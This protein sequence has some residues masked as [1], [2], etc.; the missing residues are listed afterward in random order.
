[1]QTRQNMVELISRHGGT[2]IF[3]AKDLKLDSLRIP[4]DGRAPDA[5]DLP[6]S[7]PAGGD[8]QSPDEHH[9]DGAGNTQ[10]GDEGLPPHTEPKGEGVNTVHPP[11]LPLLRHDCTLHAKRSNLC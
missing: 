9:H 8:G 7:P 10:T 11:P 3:H 2:L 4:L 6:Q 5:S 1:M